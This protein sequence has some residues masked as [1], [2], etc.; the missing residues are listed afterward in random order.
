MTGRSKKIHKFY[1]SKPWR[2]F[3]YLRKIEEKG[4]CNRCKA[5]V[6]D[7]SKLIC[8]HITELTEGNVDDPSISLS[9]E[10]T[11]VICFSCHNKEHRR[12][13][14]ERQIYIVWGSP[15]AG[16]HSMVRQLVQHGDLVVDMDSLWE[17]VTF[18]DVT[19]KPNN[20]RFNVFQL[21]DSLLDQV[22]TRFGQWSDAYIIG[23]YPDRYKRDRLAD[24][25]GAETIYCESTLQECLR[26]REGEKYP[27]IYDK[28]I[29]EWWETHERHMRVTNPPPH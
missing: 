20:V 17:A 24:E 16:K 25:L 5:V 2:D 18:M 12:F 11:E 3:A 7:T 19:N 28:Y 29:K 10:N 15:L 23:G 22:K 1:C 27:A 6:F 8:H 4:I 9:H 14:Y 26:R 21:R 13:G